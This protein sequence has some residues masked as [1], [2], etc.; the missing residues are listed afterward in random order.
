MLAECVVDQLII[1]AAG[2]RIDYSGSLVQ[3]LH[4]LRVLIAKLETRPF[5]KM[6]IQEVGGIR[7]VGSPTQ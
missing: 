4:N 7:V 2:R 3:V 6:C 5:T 1:R